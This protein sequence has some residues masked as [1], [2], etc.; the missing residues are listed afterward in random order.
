MSWKRLAPLPDTVTGT[1]WR[2]A[3]QEKL[4]A[5]AARLVALGRVELDNHPTAALAYAVASLEL[6]DSYEAR[7]FALRA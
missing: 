5:E 4:R 2:R 3:E 7:V 1:L 6:A